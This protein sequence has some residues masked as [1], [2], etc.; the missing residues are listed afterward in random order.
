MWLFL[1]TAAEATAKVKTEK[2]TADAKQIALVESTKERIRKTY[3]SVPAFNYVTDYTYKFSKVQVYYTQLDEKTKK[4]LK[5][6][7]HM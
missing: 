6:S 1:A 3:D 7:Q 4:S 5:F 2:D